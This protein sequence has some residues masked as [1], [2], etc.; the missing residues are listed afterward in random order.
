MATY[1][2]WYRTAK[3][4]SCTLSIKLQPN[5]LTHY[6]VVSIQTLL[7]A[8]YMQQSIIHRPVQHVASCMTVERYMYM[9]DQLT[10][11][12]HTSFTSV[13]TSP[14]DNTRASLFKPR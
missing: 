11:Y 4:V 13:M 8:C 2:T 14:T 5:E 6:T 10:P 3:V 9:Y 12:E 7:G 1:N